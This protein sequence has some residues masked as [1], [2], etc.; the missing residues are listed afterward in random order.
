MV[1]HFL[2]IQ[3]N[4]FREFDEKIRFFKTLAQHLHVND[5]RK[6][7]VHSNDNLL[8]QKIYQIITGYAEDDCTNELTEDHHSCV[9]IAALSCQRCMNDV[10]LSQSIM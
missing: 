8:R 3:V 2:L 1:A 4:F 9:V 7:H 5:E 10:K 6:Y